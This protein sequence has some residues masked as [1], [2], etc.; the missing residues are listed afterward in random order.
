M[1]TTNCVLHCD[2]LFLGFNVMSL[3]LFSFDFLSWLQI[4]ILDK[5]SW[6]L[7]LMLELCIIYDLSLQYRLTRTHLES[8]ISQNTS[9]KITS[10]FNRRTQCWGWG[11]EMHD[12][13]NPVLVDI[14]CQELVETLP[15]V[16]Q[17]YVPRR[18]CWII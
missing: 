7:P 16:Q 17:E 15:L 6:L 14:V 8:L 18:V 3:W 5:Y 12:G 1:R 4:S 2:T 10:T 13:M 9:I 11:W